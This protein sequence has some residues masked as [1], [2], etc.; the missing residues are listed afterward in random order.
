MIETVGS[1]IL[2]AVVT[3]VV[4][5]LYYKKAGDELRKEAAELRRLMTMMLTSMERQGGQN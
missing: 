3:W 4:S 5:Q 1:F 2:G